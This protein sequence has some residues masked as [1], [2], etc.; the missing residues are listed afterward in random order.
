MLESEMTCAHNGN[1]LR[2]IIIGRQIKR[3]VTL[4]LQLRAE[5]KK[6]T[7]TTVLFGLLSFTHW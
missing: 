6:I 1:R 4:Y 3:F 7:N 2:L 5:I